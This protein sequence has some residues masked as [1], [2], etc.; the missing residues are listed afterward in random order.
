MWDNREKIPSWSSK[1]IIIKKQNKNKK[2]VKKVCFYLK[3]YKN[4]SLIPFE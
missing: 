4:E 2:L 1:R 3:F